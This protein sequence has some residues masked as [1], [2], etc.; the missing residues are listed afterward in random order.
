MKYLFFTLSFILVLC[1][2]VSCQSESSSIP[3]VEVIELED[4]ETIYEFQE[5]Q[6][7]STAILSPSII[8]YDDQSNLYVYDRQRGK[9]V[10]L[11]S[12]GDIVN[13]Y[14]R[15]GRG[16]G[17]FRFINRITL[18]Q[19][20]LYLVDHWQFFIHKYNRKGELV[21]AMNYG[22]YT[23]GGQSM[24]NL[25]S[26]VVPEGIQTIDINNRP[27]VMPEGKVLLPLGRDK[28]DR[29]IYELRDW[30]GNY[31][32]DI[33][34]VPEGSLFL[35]EGGGDVFLSAIENREIPGILKRRAFPVSDQANHG[36]LFLIYS[37]TARIVKYDTT[38]TKLWERKIQP[39]PEI[40][41]V[42]RDYFKTMEKQN[43]ASNQRNPGTNIG[44]L[45]KYTAGVSSPEG[46][47][48]LATYTDPD[49][50]VSF[51]E[52]SEPLWIHRF[53]SEGELARRYKM[54]SGTGTS[55][56]SVFDID[57]DDRRIFVVTNKAEIRAYP[58]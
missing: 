6:F 39:T 26:A 14:G 30:E 31:L 18:Q 33:G 57:F 42:T 43:K 51:S 19:N 13:E 28:V 48:Y 58:F 45:R 32:A 56:P 16:P 53:S 36:E 23:T 12:V 41:A 10:E 15:V 24:L 47:L 37:A 8:T 40:E 22:S 9:V 1:T 21:S 50:T 11:D 25:L 38:G 54:I 49:T 4:Y 52:L 35:P 3:S 55:L 17:E 5:I 29:S 2:L 27:Y 44:M 7:D 46:E 34:E 20:G